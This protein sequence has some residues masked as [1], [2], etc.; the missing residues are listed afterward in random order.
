MHLGFRSH[1]PA[2]PFLFGKLEFAD[3]VI[4]DYTHCLTKHLSRL[5]LTTL[6]VQLEK[7]SAAGQQLCL[8]SELKDFGVYSYS[9]PLLFRSYFD[10]TIMA[11]DV[12][13]FGDGP[14]LSLTANYSCRKSQ[15]LGWWGRADWAMSPARSV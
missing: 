10:R 4:I 5:I 1:P 3:L 9:C 14:N 13:L 12:P 2:I 7:K 15:G 8:M 6:V 11:Y